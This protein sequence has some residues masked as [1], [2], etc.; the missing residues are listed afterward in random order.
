MSS[1]VEKLHPALSPG[2]QLVLDQ[3][4]Q[5]VFSRQGHWDA[6]SALHCAAMALAMLGKLPD[7]V[8]VRDYDAGPMAHFWDRAY[9]HYLHG[10]VP[11]EMAS[12]IWELNL[13]ILPVQAQSPHSDLMRFC[14]SELSTGWPVIARIAN[15][16][17]SA[18]HAA[19][20]VGVEERDETLTALLVLDPNCG[21]P[22]LSAWN[23]RLEFGMPDTLYVTAETIAIPVLLDGAVSLRLAN[24]GTT[25]DDCA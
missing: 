21:T 24:A 10:L 7:P 17:N 11:S 8:E 5:P 16:A 15:P 25:S 2:Q 12:F 1:L 4:R 20:V 14:C 22:K 23:A 9:P 13:G 3:S 19:L 6:G 18:S